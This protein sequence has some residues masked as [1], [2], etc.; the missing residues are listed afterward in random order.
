MKRR[1]DTILNTHLVRTSKLK[2]DAEV[3]LVEC[4]QPRVNQPAQQR[5]LNLFHDLRSRLFRIV[6]R[7]ERAELVVIQI[8]LSRELVAGA[9]HKRQ[10]RR[11]YPERGE[12]GAEDELVVFRAVGDEVEGCLEVVEEGVDV[13]DVT[14]SQSAMKNSDSS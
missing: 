7:H 9:Q 2:I 6:L 12:H 3:L 14:R 8:V 4:L 5:A 13:W 10:L 11:G 1:A